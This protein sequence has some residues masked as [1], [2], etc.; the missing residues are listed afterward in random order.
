MEYISYEEFKKI[1]MR[2]GK[3]VEAKK[4]EG[5]EKLLELKVDFGDEQ[6]IGIAGIA[7][8]YKP[9]DLIGKKFVFVVN[10]LPKKMLNRT[11]EVMILAAVKN[12][13]LSLI[14]IDKDI[15]EGSE[16]D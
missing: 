5:S 9:E 13:N 3:V 8:W 11:S 15:E 14:T 7:K 10:L 1:K 12:E 6:K 16:V 2:V 4:V